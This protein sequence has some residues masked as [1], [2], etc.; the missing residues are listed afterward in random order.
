[1]A[2]ALKN[3]TGPVTAPAFQYAV[4]LIT[5]V[6]A[7]PGNRA[8]ALLALADAN[9]G[10]VSVLIDMLKAT[11]KG[12]ATTAAATAVMD[13]IETKAQVVPGHYAIDGKHVEVKISK[14]TKVAYVIKA[15][16]YMP[17]KWPE[18]QAILADVAANGKAYA[19]AYAA[20][21]GKCG[22]CNTK[23]TDP[24]SVAAGIGPVCAKKF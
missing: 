6:H 14:I 19:I 22:V 3:P 4:D 23:L 8:E 11:L 24:K 12:Q 15:G 5:K 7:D 1:M 20:A 9:A 13:K 21:T 16:G 18:T 17:A 2:I 10:E